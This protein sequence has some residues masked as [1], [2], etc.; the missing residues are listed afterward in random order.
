MCRAR[1]GATGII[2]LCTWRLVVKHF[3]F[4]WK[5]S[6][7][8]QMHLSVHLCTLGILHNFT[9]E[10]SKVTFSIP[11]P[12]IPSRNK[13]NPPDLGW[14]ETACLFLCTSQ[15]RIPGM[16]KTSH[17]RWPGGSSKMSQALPRTWYFFLSDSWHWK[18][19]LRFSLATY[20]IIQYW[21]KM[22]L[23]V[24][25][26]SWQRTF[27]WSRVSKIQ[28]G[29]PGRVE[30]RWGPP[31]ETG[32][33]APADPSEVSRPHGSW[34]SFILLDRWRMDLTAQI[35]FG[36]FLVRKLLIIHENVLV[37]VDRLA[38]AY[39]FTPAC[40]AWLTEFPGP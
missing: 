36:Q 21:Y 8:I 27:D 13:T 14:K 12:S 31:I 25:L 34:T 38:K 4:T 15:S 32:R 1:L 19:N 10:C 35:T 26:K 6:L 18:R 24:H 9:I 23:Q 40:P 37:D 16:P 3:A 20:N 29:Y 30:A 5:Q 22:N 17:R 7:S 33:G 11:F 2:F 28:G 39:S